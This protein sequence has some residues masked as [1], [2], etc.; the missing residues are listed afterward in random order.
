[1]SPVVAMV[2]VEFLTVVARNYHDGI[3]HQALFL[4]RLEYLAQQDVVLVYRVAIQVVE[5]RRVHIVA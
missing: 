4:Q 1:M 5:W 3:V 2:L